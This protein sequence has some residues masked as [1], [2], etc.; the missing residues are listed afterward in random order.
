MDN[1]EIF[2]HVFEHARD[3]VLVIDAATGSLLD[4]NQAAVLAYGYERAELLN[5]TIFDLR[6]SE[7]P[8]VLEQMNVANA[9][10]L[11]FDT[12]H[13]RRDGSTFPVEV[14]SRGGEMDGRPY[15]FSIIRDVTERKRLEAERE[16]TLADIQR[17][18]V[19]RDEFVM[20]ASHEL[21]T[22]VTN[23]SLQLQ[24]L[25]RQL[26][27]GAE[28]DD[29]QALGAAALREAHRLAGLIDALLIAAIAKGEL[30]LQRSDVD[31]REVLLDVAER[32][33]VRAMESGSEIVVSVDQPVRGRWDRLRVDQ[34]LTNLLVNAVKYGRGKAVHASARLDGDR[35]VLEVT[36][37][38]FGIQ[39]KDAERIFDKFE[40]ALPV[41]Y[42]GLGLGLFIAR[43][44]VSAHHGSIE[45]ESTVGVGTTFRVSLPTAG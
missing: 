1:G 21:L 14:S 8:S 3:I 43:Q 20:I 4:A 11:L 40:R 30:A 10:G 22:P 12:V 2:A 26:D 16:R 34:V 17:A 32:M 25:T 24:H 18:L 41:N 37:E 36:D 6:I 42:G 23:I 35:A 45:L 39:T 29:V 38:G 44:I 9:R 13:R 27:R 33:R 15:L 5:L 19:L 28:R 31:L 7:P